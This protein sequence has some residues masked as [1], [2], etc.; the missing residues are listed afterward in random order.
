MGMGKAA[1]QQQ[2]Q[3]QQQPRQQQLPNIRLSPKKLRPQVVNDHMLL[4][5]GVLTVVEA[6]ELIN[7]A[8]R[9]GFEHQSSRG[10]AYGEA[11][12]CDRQ[13]VALALL[14]CTHNTRAAVNKR[15]THKS[16]LLLT[17]TGC[18]PTHVCCLRITYTHRDN[19]RI[20]M[21]DPGLAEQLWRVAGL[22]RVMAGVQVDGLVPVGLNPNIRYYRSASHAECQGWCDLSMYVSDTH[23]VSDNGSS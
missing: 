21:H 1:K 14:L 8:T 10:P 13:A 20:S 16:L 9:L 2:P 4:V 7:A 19:H 6:Q 5:P 15:H 3:Q 11:F 18:C 17:N 23:Y 22:E 12:R